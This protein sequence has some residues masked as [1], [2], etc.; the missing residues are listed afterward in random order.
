[1]AS[2]SGSADLLRLPRVFDIVISDFGRETAIKLVQNV[3]VLEHRIIR[4]KL[5]DPTFK[6]FDEYRRIMFALIGDI[7]YIKQ[8]QIDE[9]RGRGILDSGILLGMSGESIPASVKERLTQCIKEQA[10]YALSR[11]YRWIRVVIP[12]NTLSPI[13][14]GLEVDLRATIG[15]A[16]LIA[17]GLNTGARTSDDGVHK[18]DDIRF[19]AWTVPQTVLHAIQRKEALPTDLLVLGTSTAVSTYREELAQMEPRPAIKILE[20][21]A[22]EQEVVNEAII[23]AIDGDRGEI[24][25]SRMDILNKIIEPRR[26]SGQAFTIIEA[27]TDF[28]LSVGINSLDFFTKELVNDVYDVIDKGDEHK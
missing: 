4:S 3:A 19:H 15:S 28:E 1:M 26:A 20:L 6:F 12:C 18:V 17:G 16:K 10:M 23:A 14:R 7:A 25:R 21:T 27:C 5:K 13:S 24:D 22:E 2:N 8:P 9:Y 11:G